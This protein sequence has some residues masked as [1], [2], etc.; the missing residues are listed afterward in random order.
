MAK[1]FRSKLVDI[2]T[3][4]VVFLTTF[5]GLI[6][7]MP[8]TDVSII[9]VVSAVTMFLVSAITVWKQY[10][11]DEIANK[12]LRPTIIVAILATI[13]GVMDLMKVI[14]FNHTAGQWIR[15]GFTAVTMFLN[16]FSKLMY[17]TDET[18]SKI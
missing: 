7:T 17:D 5:Q 18:K 16:L 6:P 4:T 2:F 1:S 9:A 11:S 13:A 3:I 15:F 12:A 14:D 10:I 8:I